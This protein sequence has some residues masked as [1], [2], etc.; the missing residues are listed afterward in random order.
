METPLAT[1]LTSYHYLLSSFT[2]AFVATGILHLSAMNRQRS[3]S[4]VFESVPSKAVDVSHR[5]SGRLDSW[6]NES[7]ENVKQPLTATYR[8]SGRIELNVS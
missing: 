1:M 2:A 5:G 8:G 7:R 4:G 3:L 6:P